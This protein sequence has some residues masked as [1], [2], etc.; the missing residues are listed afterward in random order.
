MRIRDYN[1]NTDF[2]LI[3][4]WI[5]DERTHAM[6]CANNF[7]YPLDRDNFDETL[8]SFAE[9]YGDIPF[10][11][12]TDSGSPVGFFCYSE[13]AETNEGLLKFVLV[14]PVTR[15]KGIA[16][17]MI[18]LAASNAFERTTVDAV[19]LNV[20][21]ENGRALKCYEHVGFVVRSLYSDVFSFREEQWGRCNMALVRA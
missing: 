20:F 10:I 16:R 17:Q 5:S 8:L 1:S 13:N 15:G 12:T 3:K 21:T 19:Q 9:R 11:A 14:D 18:K 2:E 7:S 4:S 6:W